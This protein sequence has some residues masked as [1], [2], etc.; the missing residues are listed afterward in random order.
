MKR[1]IQILFLSMLAL[2]AEPVMKCLTEWGGF[3]NGTGWDGT[4]S[5]CSAPLLCNDG[6]AYFMAPMRAGDGL[7]ETA[8]T[9]LVALYTGNPFSSTS[10]CT[11]FKSGYDEQFYEFS[12]VIYPE[13]IIN[14]TGRLRVAGNRARNMIFCI[15]RVIQRPTPTFELKSVSIAKCAPSTSSVTIEDGNFPENCTLAISGDG[16]LL[17]VGDLT[18]SYHFYDSSLN[19]VGIELEGDGRAVGISPD[20]GEVLFA[21]EAAL[22]GNQAGNLFIYIYDREDGGIRPLIQVQDPAKTR[23]QNG[24]EIAY[25]ASCD[26]FAFVT[27]RNELLDNTGNDYADM[28][29]R[30]VILAR[31]DEDGEWSFVWCDGGSHLWN[32]GA[33]AISADGRYVAFTAS[34]QDGAP[35]QVFRY[36]SVTDSVLRVSTQSSVFDDKSCAAT[37]ISPNGRFVGFV[38]RPLANG[39]GKGGWRPGNV[40][41]SDLGP[42]LEMDAESY[43]YGTLP[44]SFPLN[45]VAGEEATLTISWKGT[46][47]CEMYR[48]VGNKKVTVANGVPF[49]AMEGKLYL[50]RKK[51]GNVTVHVTLVDGDCQLN[52][53][54]IITCL[55]RSYPSLHHLSYVM[56][57]S[58]KVLATA[59]GYS[60]AGGHFAISG[61][62]KTVAF[63]TV[64]KSSKESYSST[65][66]VVRTLA[67]FSRTIEDCGITGR[68]A[69]TWDGGRLFFLTA[70]GVARYELPDGECTLAIEGAEAFA[71]SKD[72]TAFAYVKGGQPFVGEECLSLESGFS[73]PQI[74]GDGKVAAFLNGHSLYVWKGGELRELADGVSQAHLSMSGA[75]VLVIQDDALKWLGAKE[76]TV[77]LPCNISQLKALTLSANGRFLAYCRNDGLQQAFRYDLLSGEEASMSVRPDGTYAD[78]PVN[79][80]LAIS[81]DGARMLFATAASNFVPGKAQ[82]LS[83]E[84]YMAEAKNDMNTAASPAEVPLSYNETDS[85]VTLPISYS[86]SEAND[87][88]PELLSAPSE[89]DLELLAPDWEHPWYSLRCV[90]RTAHCCGQFGFKMRFWDG[91]VWSSAKEMTLNVVNVNDSPFWKEDAPAEYAVA[92]GEDMTG[93]D[94]NGYADD[95]DLANPAPYGGEELSIEL[96][97]APDWVSVDAGCLRMNPG[98]DATVSGKTQSFDF[99]VVAKDKAGATAELPVSVI[100]SNTNR[101]PQLAYD[102]VVILE[103]EDVPWKRFAASDPDQEDS[104]CIRITSKGGKWRDKS[105]NVISGDVAEDRFPIRFVS[106]GRQYNEQTASYVAVDAEAAVSAKKAT[107]RILLNKVRCNASEIWPELFDGSAFGWRQLSTPFAVDAGELASLFGSKLFVYERVKFIEA[108]G[109]LRAGRGFLVY[110]QATPTDALISGERSDVHK[111]ANGWNLVGATLDGNV[112]DEPGFAIRDAVNVKNGGTAAIGSG[113]WIFVRDN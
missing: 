108:E 46:L 49:P 80:S 30:Q 36:D 111:I 5:F 27:N 6:T 17:A 69:L 66:L 53:D 16:S 93:A 28:Y 71:V 72:G 47:P 84:L 29:G 64:A 102:T 24:A 98:Y 95:F 45:V 12:K 62:G 13:G 38:T 99:F 44:V 58:D 55:E 48:L 3:T 2:Y 77:E 100:V 52:S 37:A 60:I 83:N 90:S 23:L 105:G 88:I 110:L 9:P 61:D 89:L 107:V 76:E 14:E 65:A 56:D 42:V 8:T 1:V 82:D 10:E 68:V 4:S 32:C 67:G 20:G 109:I 41:I 25:A 57:G 78:A 75:S 81:S 106:D 39:D 113:F 40:W 31:R 11:L 33:P 112:P 22:A 34:E 97:N 85:A 104:L 63:T 86:D 21:S 74:S 73:S 54:S 18:A 43:V 91:T 96:R 51:D 50:R 19:D 59:G 87:V 15:T 101:S 7:P 70:N 79:P 103:G 94:Y 35:S 26:A 92:E